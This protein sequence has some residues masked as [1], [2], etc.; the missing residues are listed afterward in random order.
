GRNRTAMFGFGTIT[1]RC[2]PSTT[3][4]IFGR[5]AWMRS[6]VKPPEDTALV[7]VDWS[8]QEY[9]IGA[10][11][12]NDGAMIADY[13][14]GAP[15]LGFARRIGMVPDDA[16]KETHRKQRD[17]IKTVILGTQYGMGEQALAFRI[18]QPLA[19]ARDLL[20]AHRTTYPKF[21][22]WADAAVNT[23]LFRG[24]LWTRF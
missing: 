15:Y 7:I 14:A 10:V 6:L 20:R 1:G 17:I 22:T 3:K 24:R 21:W 19:Y 11:L 23:A 16:T 2:A 13:Q 12:A 8:S 4:F 18:G 9:G 5:P